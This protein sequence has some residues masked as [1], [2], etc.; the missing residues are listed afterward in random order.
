M[1]KAKVRVRQR[2]TLATNRAEAKV[3]ADQK[4]AAR[5]RAKRRGHVLGGWTMAGSGE[6]M[7]SWCE[8]CSHA[9]L[10]D[11]GRLAGSALRQRCGEPFEPGR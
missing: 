11:L 3:L 6:R 5:R 1:K 10:V 4:K 2:R 9:A 8:Q 7:I